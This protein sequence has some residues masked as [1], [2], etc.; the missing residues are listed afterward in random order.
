[1]RVQNGGQSRPFEL[2]AS[3]YERDRHFF[4]SQFFRDRYDQALRNL[5][6]IQSG[7]EVRN[8]EVYI[9]NDNRQSDNLRNVVTL[10]DLA[11][12]NRVYRQNLLTPGPGIRPTTPA[13]NGNNKLGALL[14][15]IPAARGEQTVDGYLSSNTNVFAQPLVKNV[16]FEHVRARKLDAR[17]YT[18][19]AQLGYLSLNTQLLPE[20]VL[21]VSYEYLY[22]GKTYKV[23]EIVNDYGNRN[24][25]QVIFLKMLRATNPG[26]GIADPTQNLQNENLR[27]RNLPTWDLMMKNIYP[28]NAS[29]LNR[30]N[31]QLQIIYKDDETGVDLI[32]LKEGAKI[33]NRPL[34]EVLN[35]DNVN[36][37]NDQN[38]DGNFD[39]FPGITIDPELGKVIFPEVEPFGSYLRAQFDSTTERALID[40]Y[41][42]QE[43]Y[44]LVQSDAQQITN[45]DKFFL[46]GRFQAT[47]TDEITLPGLGIAQGSVRVRAGSVLLEEG[48]D[49]QVF[50]DQAKVKILNPAYLNSANE[51]RIEFEKNALVQVQPRRLLGARFDYRLNQDVNIGAT[52]A[53]TRR[54]ASTAS[55]SATS[56]ATTP[57]TAST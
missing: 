12:P 53:K 24:Q 3:Q 48:R 18:L 36:P 56:P 31:F 54:P 42:Y 14:T 39:F 50:Y 19:N 33:A 35:L 16:D 34:I 28:L 30:D 8:L 46:K 47:A 45:K 15:N 22:N 10:M 26:V 9:T 44:N 13:D 11:E 38:P 23:G 55:T 1:V 40:K 43:L 5:P 51:L 52:C 2:K 6:T 41:V 37:N 7:I 4:L 27:T 25:D 49:Y 21:G 20:Q 32:S 57:S 17:E 29:Q